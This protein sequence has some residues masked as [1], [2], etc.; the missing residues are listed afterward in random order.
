MADTAEVRA[1]V[2][3]LF[4]RADGDDPGAVAALFCDDEDITFWGSDAP[5]A[6]VGPDAVHALTSGV[7]AAL[8]E[9]S[10][11]WDEERVQVE[12]DVAWFNAAGR[13]TGRTAEGSVKIPYRLTA[14]LV[15]RDGIWRWHTFHGSEPGGA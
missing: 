3:E 5:E 8:E 6:A 14:V 2:G 13:F 4:V 15:R 10:V 1:L 11:D 9:V 7:V 12:G